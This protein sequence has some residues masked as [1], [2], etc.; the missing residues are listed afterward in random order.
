MA[1]KFSLKD[2][3]Q[4]ITCPYLVTHGGND[5]VV[6]VEN[7]PKLYEAIG[8]KNKTLKIFDAEEGGAEHCQVDDRQAGVNFIADWITENIVK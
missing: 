7:A 1:K 8:S 5:R 4:N 2:V 6:P 3:A